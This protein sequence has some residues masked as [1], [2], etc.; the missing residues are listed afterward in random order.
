MQSVT[1]DL[2]GTFNVYP[3]LS[4]LSQMVS[5]IDRRCAERRT[6]AAEFECN[7]AATVSAYHLWHVF[8]PQY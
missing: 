4:D 8:P 2:Q 6:Q 3:Q 1:G 7:H 5:P